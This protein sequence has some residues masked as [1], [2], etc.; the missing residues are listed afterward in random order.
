MVEFWFNLCSY[1]QMAADGH[2]EISDVLAVGDDTDELYDA[3]R[4]T[5]TGGI[6]PFTY[7][8]VAQPAQAETDSPVEQITFVQKVAMEMNGKARSSFARSV[9]KPTVVEERALR[10]SAKKM[11]CLSDNDLDPI[12]SLEPI[13][14]DVLRIIAARLYQA[15]REAMAGDAVA[16]IRRAFTKCAVMRRARTEWFENRLREDPPDWNKPGVNSHWLFCHAITMGGS[17]RAWIRWKSAKGPMPI[18]R[19]RFWNTPLKR[20]CL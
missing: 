11:A 10:L 9:D 7:E 13:C 19:S 5:L 18:P 12:G 4:K 20:L 6:A 1:C 14:N 15:E 8:A 17:Y 16:T 3:A 2:M